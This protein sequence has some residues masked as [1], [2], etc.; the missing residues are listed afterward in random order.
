MNTTQ[1]TTV[2]QLWAFLVTAL[3]LVAALGL[4]FAEPADAK[5][6][7]TAPPASSAR[8]DSTT[9]EGG[10]IFPTSVP[11]LDDD[12]EPAASVQMEPLDSGVLV[13]VGGFAAHEIA[14]G[15]GVLVAVLDGGFD[16]AHPTLA[17]H[18]SPLGW[19]CLDDDGEISDL[20]N[21]L[22]DDGDGVVDR[23]VGH[24]TAVSGMV[25]LAAPDATILPIRVR[26][27]E[28]R[29]SNEALVCGIAHAVRS[30]ADVINLSLQAAQQA[31]GGVKDAIAVAQSFGVVVVTSAGNGGLTYLP[32]AYGTLLVGAVDADGTIAPFS[33]LPNEREDRTRFVFAPGV[34]IHVPLWAGD[35]PQSGVWSGT[36]LSAGF[37]SGSVALMLELLPDAPPGQVV[38]VVRAT[39]STVYEPGG[40][41]YKRA[42]QIDL[43]DLVAACERS[44]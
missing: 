40:A 4:L 7:K 35:R 34:D 18:L 33:N 44:R 17:E 10:D 24:G 6:D 26:D 31:S 38:D 1:P 13:Q 14:T 29:G 27:D 8:T 42:G 32:F 22:D 21:G 25:L 36:S 41:R 23:A 19:D 16:L 43:L 5:K 30:G 20:G 3:S 37:V 28:G 11:V 12:F 15:R 2:R 9:R 39:A